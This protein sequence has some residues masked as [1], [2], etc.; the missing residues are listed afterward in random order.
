MKIQPTKRIEQHMMELL[1]QRDRNSAV[2]LRLLLPLVRDVQNQVCIQ[3]PERFWQQAEQFQKT[4][5]MPQLEP[6]T[7]EQAFWMSFYWGY[8]TMAK[9]NDIFKSNYEFV[10]FM[11]ELCRNGRV[12]EPDEFAQDPFLRDVTFEECTCGSFSMRTQSY[13]PYQLLLCGTTVHNRELGV[14]LPRLGCFTQQMQFPV[15]AEGDA[16]RWAVSPNQIVTTRP[17]VQAARG[18]VLVLGCGTGYYAYLASLKEDVE[19]VT[20]VEKSPEVIELFARHILPQFA[21]RDKI[22]IVQGDAFEYLNELND[23]F[24]DSCFAQLWPDA[25]DE[26]CELYLRLRSA[27]RRFKR[28]RVRYWIEDALA[29]HL[30]PLAWM[31]LVQASYKL[32]HIEKHDPMSLPVQLEQQHQFVATLLK[33]ET[34]TRPEQL[35]EYLDPEQLIAR[36]NQ[37]RLEYEA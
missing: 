16:V 20:I 27:C 6:L 30:V 28:M 10:M 8:L 33:K 26:S 2:A 7:R 36:M 37:A 34:V 24:Y 22:R 32:Y 14:E 18:R 13:A 15:I 21:T 31:E 4:F 23:G 3:Q 11:Y 25:S 35:D 9:A 5:V 12:M 29:A 1:G 17:H 19:S